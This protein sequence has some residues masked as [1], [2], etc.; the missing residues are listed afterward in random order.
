MQCSIPVVTWPVGWWT[1]VVGGPPVLPLDFYKQQAEI[2]VWSEECGEWR[3]ES[4]VW[5][6]EW[7][8]WRV[9]SGV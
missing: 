3:V 9:G 2:G 8:V 4:E 1:M 5:S 7:G 6:V